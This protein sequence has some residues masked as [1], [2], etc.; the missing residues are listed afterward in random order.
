MTRS[1]TMGLLFVELIWLLSSMPVLA[2]M[3]DNKIVPWPDGGNFDF[4]SKD[5]VKKERSKR[6]TGSKLIFF[7]IFII[8]FKNI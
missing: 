8:Q 7:L 5:H 4:A 2:D 1:S 3:K 6:D